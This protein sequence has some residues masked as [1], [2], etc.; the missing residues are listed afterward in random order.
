MYSDQN[1]GV[2]VSRRSILALAAAA[3]FAA[4]LTSNG[5]AE[6]ARPRAAALPAGAS[7]FVS[8][9]PSRLA[10][11][12][13]DQN[14][15]GFTRLDANTI[16]VQ[17]A[18]RGNVPGNATAAVLN[19]TAVNTTLDGFVSVYP[20]GADRPTAS[21]LNVEKA[22]Q[23]IPNL[24]TVRLGANGSVDV[25]TQRAA[26]L[27]VDIN[28]AYV[29]ATDLVSAGRFVGLETAYRAID[30]R[31]L[32]AKVDVK[33]V[34][35]VDLTAVVPAT[36]SAV[37][38]NLTVTESN[39]PGFWTGFAAGSAQPGSSSL[40]TD[41]VNQTRANQAILP[42]GTFA[43]SKRGID[44]YSS[45]GGHL[46]VDVAGYFTGSLDPLAS[47]G[48]FVPSTPYRTLD[49]RGVP[50]YGRMYAGWIAEFDYQGRD[51]SQA[52][53][54]NLTTTETRAAG[55]F[56]GYAARTVRPVAS[57]LNATHPNQ[58][59][60]NHAILRASTAGVAVFT[61]GGGQLIVD[62]AGYFMGTPT[63]ATQP[64]AVNIIPPPPPPAPLP[65]VLTMPGLGLTMTVLEGIGSNVVDAG[66]AGHWPGTGYAGEQSHMMFFAHRT[67]HGG[68]WRNIHLLG[69][70]DQ[71][72]LS[73]PD[74]RVFHYTWWGRAITSTNATEIYN[75]GL[76]APIPSVSLVA[77]SKTNFLPTDV[78]YRIV[79]TYTLTGIDG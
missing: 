17:I 45:S 16:R 30:T 50:S 8:V 27:I 46:I 21:S 2:S 48:L 38:V 64:M 52:V 18:G 20:S 74:G 43:A 6:A 66:N 69:A 63:P 19:V 5:V 44:V 29:P 57:N 60:A 7:S 75:V 77:C 59:V 65:Y 14:V 10:D 76:P 12:R 70:G 15:G 53:V 3:P 79:V 49:T 40:N 73:S 9:T 51:Q 22:G 31:S 54:V 42:I 24:V 13:P 78:N 34:V 32:G 55:Y 35:R 23:V 33:S 28:G 1:I 41:D 36:A 58:T 4:A 26:D 56:T 37:V 62:V 68:P 71:I 67:A 39:G 72:S 47:D 61:Q 11:T 25:Y